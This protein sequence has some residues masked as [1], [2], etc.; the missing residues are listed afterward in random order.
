MNQNDPTIREMCEL[1]RDVLECRDMQALRTFHQHGVISRYEHCLSVCYIAL[2]LADKWH[3]DVDRRSMVRGALLHDFFMYDG[4]DPG[5]LRLLHGFTHAKEALSNARK[6][7]ELNEVECDVIQKHMFPLNIAPPKYWETV[8]V[9]A[10]LVK[11]AAGV[12]G[13]LAVLAVWIGPFLRMGAQYL[14]WKGATALCGLFAPKRLTGVVSDFSTAMGLLLAM[15]GTVCLFWLVS[16]VCFL[17]GVG[18]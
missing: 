1:G 3:V 9:S 17:K 8:L 14:V 7:F 11:N 2:R 16:T 18:G 4:H 15:L 6:Q 10:G 12:Y 5:N 13:L